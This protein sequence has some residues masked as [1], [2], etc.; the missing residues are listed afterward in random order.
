MEI[1]ALFARQAQ[2]CTE[3]GSPF[4]GRVLR[5]VVPLLDPATPLGQRVLTFPATPDD[6][7]P[8]RLAGAL[9][10][11]ARSGAALAAVY[12]PHS[13]SDTALA[14]G[15]RTALETEATAL[16]PWI[17]SA[18]QTNEVARSAVLI[19]AGHWLTARFGL[20]LVLSELGASAGLNLLWDHYGLALPGSLY[21]PPDPVLSFAPVWTG[22]L[23][24]AV[25]PVIAD[26]AGVDLS[27]LDPARDRDRMLAYIWADQ[28]LRL[29]RAK[30]ALTLAARIRPGVAQG[31]AADW[32]ETRLQTPF[33]GRIHLLYHT[34]ASQYFP[35]P[36]RDRIA[37]ALQTAG[38]RA[39]PTA[40]LAH[41]AMEGDGKTGS[42]VLTLT[43]WPGGASL[44]VGRADFHGRWVVW[45]PP[46]A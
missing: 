5:L 16:L 32:A 12:P 28:T 24:V 3:M 46:V 36:I 40:P 10:A 43:A 6:A 26:R 11:L 27:P 23:P 31:D 25:R 42:A 4:T 7:L 38:A 37:A 19:A 13:A 17:D 2:A 8:L 29:D 35:D 34:V 22:A 33:P 30:A 44:A 9:H 1:A 21:G 45:H 14:A 39:T 18:P 41:F 15:L 20:P